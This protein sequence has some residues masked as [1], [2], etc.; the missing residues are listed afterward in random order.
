[1]NSGFIAREK[2]GFET[3]NPW[4]RG[5]RPEPGAGRGQGAGLGL[6]AMVDDL[7]DVVAPC[8]WTAHAGR[9]PFE[10]GRRRNSANQPLYSPEERR[11]RDRS[12][13]TRVQAVLAPLQFLVFAVSLGLVARYLATGRGY[14]VATASI[15]VKTVALY[16]IM[17]TGSIWEKDVFGQW[18]FARSFFWEDVFSM[19]V[20]GLQTAYLGA[21]VTG[22][23]SPRQQMMVAI[24]AYAA[25]A[26]NASQFLLKLRAARLE[27]GGR[28]SVTSPRLGQPA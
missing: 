16:T 23:G 4:E 25:Y 19:L 28:S 11:R 6:A 14:E 17:I 3:A 15:L 2:G 9:S 12:P 24:A 27:G 22:W 21:L 5:A 8:P 1:M 7:I 10:R 13:W 18:L 26:I 20:L